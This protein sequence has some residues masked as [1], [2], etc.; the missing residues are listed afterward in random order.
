[1]VVNQSSELNLLDP[2]QIAPYRIPGNPYKTHSPAPRSTPIQT[3]CAPGTITQVLYRCMFICLLAVSISLVV[4]FLCLWG[5]G[6][7][8]F[9][10][11]C[12]AN[13]KRIMSNEQCATTVDIMQEAVP[14]VVFWYVCALRFSAP[15]GCILILIPCYDTLN[16]TFLF[17]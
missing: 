6:S 17:G 5:V 16:S 9:E 3:S 15:A 10:A 11:A 7:I 2:A 1:M 12:G 14:R 4:F 8:Q 13:N